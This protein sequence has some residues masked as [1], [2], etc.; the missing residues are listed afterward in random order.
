M[1]P[2]AVSGKIAKT[3]DISG[4]EAKMRKLL[5]CLLGLVLGGLLLRSGPSTASELVWSPINPSFVGGN[6]LMG[7]VLLN[8]AQAQN[9]ETEAKTTKSPLEEFNET[10]NRQILYRLSSK[11]VDKAFGED[12]LKNGHY[13]M[14]NFVVDITTNASGLNVS[15]IDTTSGGSTTVQ[16]PYY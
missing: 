15:I 14:G 16:V 12:E 2:G 8:E 13:M 6:P 11:M 9:K 4:K 10:L 3:W 5:V 1:V 7:P